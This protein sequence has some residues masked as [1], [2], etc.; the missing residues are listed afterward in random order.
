MR[1]FS[2]SHGS[3]DVEAVTTAETLD[4]RGMRYFLD[5]RPVPKD[6]CAELSS[7]PADFFL[8]CPAAE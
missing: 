2:S 3:F 7:V 6:S 4:I 1:A 8:L 5:R